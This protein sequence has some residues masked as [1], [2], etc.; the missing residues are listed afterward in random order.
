MDRLFLLRGATDPKPAVVVWTPRDSV[1]GGG[2][3]ASAVLAMSSPPVSRLRPT[4]VIVVVDIARA[5][6]AVAPAVD[7]ISRRGGIIG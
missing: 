1:V 5:R 3:I 2:S 7:N 6:S 4:A